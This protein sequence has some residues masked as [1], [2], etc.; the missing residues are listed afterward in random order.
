MQPS[1]W[2]KCTMFVQDFHSAG[3]N[4]T[5]EIPREEVYNFQEMCQMFSTS[6]KLPTP[7]QVLKVSPQAKVTAR[8]AISLSSLIESKPDLNRTKT[9][10]VSI[11]NSPVQSAVKTFTSKR[12]VAKTS[13]LLDNAIKD[14][15]FFEAI[16]A[17]ISKFTTGSEDR[18]RNESRILGTLKQ[19]FKSFDRTLAL[20]PFGSTTF[21]FGSAH[22]NYNILVDTRKT[23]VFMLHHFVGRFSFMYFIFAG[24]SKQ[25]QGLVLESFE[26]YLASTDIQQQFD[27]LAEIPATRTMK[28][29]LR[30]IHKESG[31]RVLLLADDIV[32]AE[33]P[34]IIRDFIAI[35]PICKTSFS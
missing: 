22:S 15:K 20:H 25:D 34:K 31:I 8:R 6:R 26:K 9:T 27:G 5:A 19:L 23:F 33:T 16:T 2:Q 3:L 29:Q 18:I 17:E 35:K 32:I 4:I 24:K 13:V 7:K 1:N 28:Q 10:K 14:G 21:G 12:N 11:P 30:I